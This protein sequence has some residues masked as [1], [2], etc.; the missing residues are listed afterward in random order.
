M[1]ATFYNQATFELRLRPRTPLLVKAG[2]EGTAAL[3]PTVPDMN[4]VRTHRT[5]HQ[6]EVFIPGASMRGVV[7]SYA[8]RLLRSIKSDLACNP[9]QTSGKGKGLRS[10]CFAAEDTTKVDGVKAYQDSCHACRLFGNTALASRVRF[11][12]FHVENVP[13]LETRYGVA[14]DRITGAVAQG[15]FEMEILTDASFFGVVTVR[16]FTLGQLGLFAAAML[17]LSDG[18]VALG[19]GKSKGLGRVQVDF[20]RF[21]VRTLKNTNGRLLGVGALRPAD[22]GYPLPR[23][24]EMAWEIPTQRVRGF[25]EANLEDDKQIRA[26]LEKVANRWPAEVGA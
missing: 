18:L 6:L 11:G 23:N 16:D 19:F 22:D 25:F 7:R 9:T 2:G 1:H 24:D 21:S 12:D 13:M 14:I 15:P 20:K 4:F 17:D 3:D 10:A 5:G 26:L 8:E